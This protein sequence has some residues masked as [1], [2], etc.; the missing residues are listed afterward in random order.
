MILA[1]ETATTV[2]STALMHQGKLLG[3]FFLNT[4][5]NH[6]QALMPLVDSLLNYAGVG[7]RDIA[8][9]GVAIGPGSF[10][11]LRI[12]L[13]TV[14]GMAMTLDKPL[15][16]I[17]TLD[18]LAMNVEPEGLICPVMDARKN[19]VYAA[20]YQTADG[21]GRLTD[22]RLTDYLVEQPAAL[23]QRLAKYG[24][25][26]TLVGDAVD[27][28][29]EEFDQHFIQLTGQANRWPRAAQVAVLTYHRFLTGGADDL[30]ALSP[31]YIR[32]SEA[33]VRWEERKNSEDGCHG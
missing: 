18:A 27:R 8:G 11:G 17:P 31:L 16:G 4:T 26:V 20:I 6:S 12:G 19:E 7:I 23:V 30:F 25:K 13:A 22:K 3:E 14:K 2:A 33:E 9:F 21:S 24:Q 15:F 1:I 32:R 29:P 10:T 28:Y 5:K